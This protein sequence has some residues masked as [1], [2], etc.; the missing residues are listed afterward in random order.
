MGRY[1]RLRDCDLT[2]DERVAYS[3]LIARANGLLDGRRIIGVEILRR[4]EKR[5]EWNLER[6]ESYDYPLGP[7]TP[8]RPC[9]EP[10]ALRLVCTYG[11]DK[12]AVYLCRRHFERLLQRTVM[13]VE[14]DMRRIHETVEE[15]LR[16]EA[17]GEQQR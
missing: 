3:I 2:A 13:M 12:F 6:D 17:R 14:R 16:E 8:E 7:Y 1:I 10:A 11:D 5:C 9:G 15:A 4:S